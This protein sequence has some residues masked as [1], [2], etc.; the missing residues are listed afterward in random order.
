MFLKYLAHL[1]SCKQTCEVGGPLLWVPGA[2]GSQRSPRMFSLSAQTQCGFGVPTVNPPGS[3]CF[4]LLPHPF[5]H[6]L[7][8]CFF[9]LTLI[10]L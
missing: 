5:P 3:W 9:L 8:S 6:L 2:Q 7:S 4:F 1:E 10:L